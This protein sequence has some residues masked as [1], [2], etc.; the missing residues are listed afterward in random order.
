MEFNT[1]KD[2]Y[3]KLMNEARIKK[4]RYIEL[5][6]GDEEDF[7][8]LFNQANEA[9]YE[10]EHIN[11]MDNETKEFLNKVN[12]KLIKQLRIDNYNYLYERF[13]KLNNIKILFDKNLIEDNVP[14]GFPILIENRDFIRTELRK[15]YIYCPVHWDIRNEHLM[16]EYNKSMYLSNKII[17]IPIDNRY[18]FQDMDRLINVITNLINSEGVLDEDI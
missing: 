14:L 8:N 10:R 13:K 18:D 2:E 16:N 5:N 9:Y 15:H 1:I 7:L 11:C 12:Y 6:S 3:C 17:T 4:T